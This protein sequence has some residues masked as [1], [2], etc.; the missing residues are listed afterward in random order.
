M[1]VYTHQPLIASSYDQATHQTRSCS[2]SGQPPNP[3]DHCSPSSDAST[4][5]PHQTY[6]S[7]PCAPGFQHRFSSICAQAPTRLAQLGSPGS[8]LEKDNTLSLSL[9]KQSLLCLLRH[10]DGHGI[11]EPASVE[12]ELVR[13][14]VNR[15]VESSLDLFVSC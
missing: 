3:T 1:C 6:H 14:R 13:N 2:L 12:L 9:F 8:P 4:W 10:E 5:P 11:V 15:F 7:Q